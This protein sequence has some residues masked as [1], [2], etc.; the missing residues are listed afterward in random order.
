MAIRI[1]PVWA[2]LAV[3]LFSRA[4]TALS[5]RVLCTIRR[6][7]SFKHNHETGIEGHH[8]SERPSGGEG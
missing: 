4:A 1:Q 3:N 6:V 2:A 8:Y 7:P 5:D